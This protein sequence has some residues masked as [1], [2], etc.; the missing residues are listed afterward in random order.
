MKYIICFFILLIDCSS[1]SQDEQS[2]NQLSFHVDS[3][4]GMFTTDGVGL[5]QYGGQT[6]GVDYSISLNKHFSFVT[7]IGAFTNL[8]KGDHRLNAYLYVPVQVGMNFATLNQRFQLELMMGYPIKLVEYN[9]CLNGTTGFWYSDKGGEYISFNNNYFL[10]KTYPV[11]RDKIFLD[12]TFKTYIAFGKQQ[13]KWFFS[14]GFHYMLYS[15]QHKDYN[16]KP[17]HSFPN[18]L[19]NV[20]FGI[21]YV[22]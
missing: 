20:V 22:L 9:S 10:S 17:F 7:A 18:H 14:T 8:R 15:T 3:Y 6:V 5:L 12:G 21:K 19:L 13:R 4:I 11:F 16:G 1:F 2:K